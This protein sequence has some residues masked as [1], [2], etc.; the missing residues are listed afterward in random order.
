M[1]EKEY[2]ERRED[3]S[4]VIG[5]RGREREDTDR[6]REREGK[7]GPDKTA[8]VWLLLYRTELSAGLLPLL[9]SRYLYDR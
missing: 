3:G 9:P 7:G 4:V 8:A 5:E 6:A 2:V 1:G